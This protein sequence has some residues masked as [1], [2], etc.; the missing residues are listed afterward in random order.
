MPLVFPP[1]PT[2]FFNRVKDEHKFEK[3]SGA[4]PVEPLSKTTWA[5]P[6]Q[7]QKP[8]QPARPLVPPHKAPPM[9]KFLNAAQSPIMPPPM[10]PQMP[11]LPPS[12]PPNSLPIPPERA[13][14]QFRNMNQNL[15]D[16]VRFEPL[17]DETMKILRQK[18]AETMAAKIP[19]PAPQTNP[20]PMI[21]PPA[22]FSPPVPE[23]AKILEGLAQ[24][25]RNASFFYANFPAP[26]GK[27]KESFAVLA[28]DSE[29]RLSQYTALLSRH[30]NRDFSPVK[31][32]I[33]TQIGTTEAIALALSEE[34]KGLVKLGNLLES[35]ADTE[36]EKPIARIIS[37]KLIGHQLLVSCSVR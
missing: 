8:P 25:E 30:F 26:A 31:A 21:P 20:P 6:P 28:R 34:S 14:E 24:D 7:P 11:P 13:A 23:A 15:P 12:P 18:N 17:D 27:I 2:A 22:A 9:Q 29:M 3:K 5:Y 36:A 10:I 35:V 1:A 37:K 16:G 33:N 32:E 4:V 19:A